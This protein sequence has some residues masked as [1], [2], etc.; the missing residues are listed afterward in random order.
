MAC[1]FAKAYVGYNKKLREVSLDIPYRPLG[2]AVVVISLT[3]FFV[4][5]LRDSENKDSR[6]FRFFHPDKLFGKPVERIAADTGHRVNL[7]LYVFAVT[8]ENRVDKVV[9]ADAVFP[10]KASHSFVGAKS[11]HAFHIPS[12]SFLSFSILSIMPSAV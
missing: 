1:V 7:L 2:D 9:Y 10:Y 11:S 12:R 4:L 3:A 8:D 6:N 5:M